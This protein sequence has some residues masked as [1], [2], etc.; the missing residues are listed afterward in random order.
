MLVCPLIALSQYP[1]SHISGNVTK[2]LITASIT[3]P[4]K[5]APLVANSAGVLPSFLVSRFDA[6]AA[7]GFFSF[8]ALSFMQFDR[9]M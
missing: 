7:Y 6:G 9:G 8:I 1:V 2:I 4:P 3:A 5:R